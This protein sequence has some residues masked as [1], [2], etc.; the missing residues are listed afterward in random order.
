MKLTNQAGVSFVQGLRVNLL[1]DI[2]SWISLPDTIRVFK[3]IEKNNFEL[4]GERTLNEIALQ[5]DKSAVYTI[6][7]EFEPAELKELKVIL[8]NPGVLPEWHP[9]KGGETFIFLDEIQIVE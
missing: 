5:E 6:V 7:F 4:I 2:K 3:K 9:G 8:T 1:K